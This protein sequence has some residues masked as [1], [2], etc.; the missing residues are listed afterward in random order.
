[1]GVGSLVTA[2]LLTVA[3]STISG[4]SAGT[5]GGGISVSPGP[6]G[7]DLADSSI[8]NSTISGN[9]A[10]TSGGGIGNFHYAARCK[11][12]DHRQLGTF[13]RGNL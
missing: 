7:V 9:S 12:H 11:L 1:M 13:W 10:G 6:V 5:S 2:T 8:V 3:N 4:N